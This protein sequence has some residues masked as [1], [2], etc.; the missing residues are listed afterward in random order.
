MPS[1]GLCC[2]HGSPSLQ[3]VILL[4]PKQHQMLERAELVCN[5]V[6]P[7]K[8]KART[9]MTAKTGLR[10]LLP[11]TCMVRVEAIESDEMG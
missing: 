10:L 5:E 4:A 9:G 7:S 1:P 11:R 8:P 2:K 3:A 6:Q